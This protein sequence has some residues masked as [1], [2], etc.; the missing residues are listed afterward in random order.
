VGIKIHRLL[1]SNRLHQA[2]MF[3]A[4][5]L[6]CG[7]AIAVPLHISQVLD[8]G[9]EL[10][11]FFRDPDSEK[12]NAT[13]NRR[14]EAALASQ[15][16]AV[17]EVKPLAQLEPSVTLVIAIDVSASLS[18]AEFS[19]IQVSFSGLVKRLPKGSQVA[20]VAIGSEYR[21][22]KQFSDDYEGTA[23]SISELTAS[24]QETSLYEAVLQSQ[25]VAQTVQKGLPKRRVVLVVTDGLDDSHRGYGQT[26]A[27]RKI[28]EGLAPIYAIGINKKN[29]KIPQNEALKSLAEI[30]R[31]SGGEF[32]E[33]MSD[34]IADALEKQV[35]NM[36]GVSV[37]VLDCT[38][39]VRN[40]A[41][42]R[43]QLAIND[44]KTI[45]SDSRDIRILSLSAVA[46]DGQKK[47]QPAAN[48]LPPPE[49]TAW[50][51]IN[52]LFDRYP[53][54]GWV[55]VVCTT[56]LLVI[57]I[58]AI[59][60][61]ARDRRGAD[62][63]IALDPIEIGPFN[64][65]GF[66]PNSNTSMSGTVERSLTYP[67]DG[68]SGRS[69]V[70]SVAGSESQTYYLGNDISIGRA[71]SNTIAISEDSRMSSRHAAISERNGKPILVDQGS[72]NG[73]YLNGT[74][75]VNA[76]PLSDGDLI[77]VGNTELRV[78]FSG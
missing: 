53:I 26:E 29:R 42:Q 2:T 3:L 39:C 14:V 24:D 41:I 52:E 45:S 61:R 33:T 37:A 15:Q 68:G 34:G 64:G 10:F 70:I 18:K 49:P 36:V 19:A 27:K 48:P 54:E 47:Q 65:V 4:G 16:L 31:L 58:R 1:R 38:G 66:S 77:V 22:L 73:T 59:V 43:L 78:Y 57:G 17:K 63:Q 7:A 5:F 12:Q 62:G 74:K 21:L 72:T 20:L 44:G 40:G 8:R 56:I 13:A 35:V 71:S 50:E 6:L 46:L 60:I 69:L 11:V 23:K 75:V 30:A 32:V 28:T 51:S 55:I 76:E 9:S 25:Q 67:A